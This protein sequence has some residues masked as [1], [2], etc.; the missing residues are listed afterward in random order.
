MANTKITDLTALTGLGAAN[1][2]V[3]PIVDV[4]V[5]MTTKKITR[6]EFFQYMPDSHLYGTA[7]AIRLQESDGTAAFD[8][9][10]IYRNLD[11]FVIQTLT[12]STVISTDFRI[13]SDA[14]GGITHEFRIAN[15]EKMR[16]NATGL[17][18]GTTTPVGLLDVNGN[19]VIR[20][21][22]FIVQAAPTSKGA[23]ATL[24]AAEL[25][26]NIITY[27]GAAA[28]LTLPLATDMEAG[29]PIGT[30]NNASFELSIINTGSGAATLTANTGFTIVGAAAV[31]NGTSGLFR[32]RRTNATTYVAYRI[33]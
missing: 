7:P 11:A 25:L 20:G 5:P 13:G 12:G 2:D 24:T 8:G 21:D 14:T 18:V 19:A 31:A 22:L 17:G 27:T 30:L 9:N 29:M 6:Q 4:T 33:A 26:T 3:I 23:A 28:A 32:I 15:V 16:L 10:K 1:A